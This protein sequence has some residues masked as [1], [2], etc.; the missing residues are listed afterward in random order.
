[1]NYHMSSLRLAL[2]MQLR[3]VERTSPP[4]RLHSKLTHWDVDNMVDILLRDALLKHTS[5]VSQISDTLFLSQL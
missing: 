5:T 3:L 4:P 2:E 1:M